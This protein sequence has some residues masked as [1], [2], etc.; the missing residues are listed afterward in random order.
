MTS[1]RH[2]LARTLNL[3]RLS[4]RGWITVKGVLSM[5]RTMEKA[6]STAMAGTTD[7]DGVDTFSQMR[8]MLLAIERRILKLPLAK[9]RL[10]KRY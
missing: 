7:S 5:G 8:R 6:Y 1:T 10:A 3:L 9:P 2:E 4:T